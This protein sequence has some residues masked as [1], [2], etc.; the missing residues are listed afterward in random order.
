MGHGGR[1]HVNDEQL[2]EIYGSVMTSR[3][4]G[5]HS[6]CPQPEAL[7]DLV[8]RE[9]S[10]QSRLAILDHVMS[11]ADCRSEFDLLRSIE[12]AGAEGRGAAQ[13][14]RRWMAPLALA[15]SVLLAVVVGRYVMPGTPEGDVVR[16]GAEGGGVTLLAP[17]A[18][19]TTGSPLL[20][21]WH[22]I[23]GAGRYRLEV[24]N[25]AGEVVLEAETADTA[26]VLHSAA[27]LE[28]GEYQ[29]WVGATSPAD[30]RSS[31]RPLRL[32]AQ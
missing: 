32:R 15:A 28:P 9:G 17:P 8:R 13:P 1:D 5:R 27:D 29:W 24:M 14:S 4:E 25:A 30:T 10:E 7:L 18:E 31:L 23:A 6:A 22:P 12:L 21:A 11:C 26:I 20:F 19:A 3:S 2:R 16:S